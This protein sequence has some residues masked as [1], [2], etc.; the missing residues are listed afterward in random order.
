MDSQTRAAAGGCRGGEEVEGHCFGNNG[1]PGKQTL[2]A[3]LVLA[4]VSIAEVADAK[5]LGILTPLRCPSG[6]LA[7]VT[8]TRQM[9]AMQRVAEVKLTRA[10][11]GVRLCVRPAVWRQQCHLSEWRH[12]SDWLSVRYFTSHDQL[13]SNTAS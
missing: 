13:N 11:T 1:P 6:L 5:P 8:P 9:L 3:N 10:P 12:M 4:R 2:M 7:S